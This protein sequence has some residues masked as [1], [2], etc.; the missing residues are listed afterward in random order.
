MQSS[1][2]RPCGQ[3]TLSSRTQATP[4]GARRRPGGAWRPCERNIRANPDGHQHV[5]SVNPLLP[6]YQAPRPIALPPRRLGAA[7]SGSPAEPRRSAMPA[8]ASPLTA[9]GRATV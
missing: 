9:R 3:M 7:G 1:P 8:P 6:A 5:F 4:Y 2:P